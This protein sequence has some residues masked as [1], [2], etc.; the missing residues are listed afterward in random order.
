M[1][2]HTPMSLYPNTPLRILTLNT[3]LLEFDMRFLGKLAPTPYLLERREALVQHI[4]RLTQQA[5]LIAL[6]EIYNTTD[7]WF[8]RRALAH[9]YPYTYFYEFKPKLSLENGLLLLSKYPASDVSFEFFRHKTQEEQ[10]LSTKGYYI[11]RFDLYNG[12]QLTL[13][14]THLTAGG[15]YSPTGPRANRIRT[16][17]AEQIVHKL[18]ADP[19]HFKVILGDLNCGPQADPE[20]F[21]YIVDAGYSAPVEELPITWDPKNALNQ[22]GHY[23]TCPPQA[24]DHI[25]LSSPLHNQLKQITYTRLFDTPNLHIPGLDVPITLSDHYGILLQAE[26]C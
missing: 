12:Q 10:I 11:Y 24:I 6:Q 9:I 17:Q 22:D 20:S 1:D 21:Q 13:L 3:A 5:D 19:A 15:L 23:R 26:W 14:N 25:L 8:V 16:H 2:I 18:H 4:L 7:K